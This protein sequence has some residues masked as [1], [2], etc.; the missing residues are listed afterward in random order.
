MLCLLSRKKIQDLHPPAQ[1]C[2]WRWCFP[3]VVQKADLQA[4]ELTKSVIRDPCPFWSFGLIW[5]VCRVIPR[6]PFMAGSHG[7]LRQSTHPCAA[8]GHHWL[9][10]RAQLPADSVPGARTTCHLGSH[11]HSL[12]HPA[13]LP[14]QTQTPEEDCLPF[15]TCSARRNRTPLSKTKG[16]YLG[17]RAFQAFG[18]HVS[19]WDQTLL[20]FVVT[21]HCFL[22]SA[23]VGLPLQ[24]PIRVP[25]CYIRLYSGAISC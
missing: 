12:A 14:N 6:S 23:Y 16:L 5:A 24:S 4:D 11:H 1:K 19:S 2:R 15:S 9:T 22:N 20:S 25:L 21:W 7:S 17:I 13:Q 8:K 18:P 10:T 3:P